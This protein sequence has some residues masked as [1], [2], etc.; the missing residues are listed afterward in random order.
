MTRLPLTLSHLSAA[1]LPLQPLHTENASVYTYVSRTATFTTQHCPQ[2]E[3][4]QWCGWSKLLRK[5][6]SEKV[7]K[8]TRT[9]LCQAAMPQM[10]LSD[11]W[12]GSLCWMTCPIFFVKILRHPEFWGFIFAQLLF[13]NIPVS[14]FNSEEILRVFCAVIHR[15]YRRQN[16]WHHC[17]FSEQLSALFSHGPNQASHTRT[18]ELTVKTI[19]V[20]PDGF[21]CLCSNTQLYQV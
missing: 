12:E 21:R 4:K 5:N 18:R 11:W 20:Q 9:C 3:R 13:F 15:T 1:Y 2:T 10:C 19:N 16:T 14:I 17:E 7:V 8:V 6:R